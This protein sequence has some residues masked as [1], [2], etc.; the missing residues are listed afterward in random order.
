MGITYGTDWWGRRD[1]LDVIR[2]R[3]S[4]VVPSIV[5]VNHALWQDHEDYLRTLVQQA[6]D[7]R[8]V[9]GGDSARAVANRRRDAWGCLWHFPG[10]YL[11]GQVI[12]HPLDDW[13]D[14]SS[15][16]PPDPEDYTDWA[17]ARERIAEAKRQGRLAV[18]GVEHGFL[19]LRLQYLRGFEGLMLDIGEAKPQLSE[20]IEV[21]TDYW[22]EVVRRWLDA[23]V[24]IVQF[25]DDLGHQH[26]LPMRPETWRQVILP[27]Y[28]RLFAL[29]READVEVYLHT[30]GYIVDIIPDLIDAGVT[31]LNPQDL[32]NGIERL[33]DLTWGK[34]SLD[35]DID[36]QSVTVF[37]TPEEIDDHIGRCVRTLGSPQG[38]L[39]LIYGAY[40]GTPAENVGA[41]MLAMQK[42]HTY[43][44]RG[45]D[46]ASG[47]GITNGEDGV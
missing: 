22:A 5:A 46:A 9:A 35:L 17:Q 30:D 14:W 31:I 20:L 44:A 11:D 7:V 47:R 39:S 27:S 16:R 19:Y 24:D 3:G 37:G 4:G 38:G 25:A 15:Y 36:R 29:C 12:E 32:V 2:R 43:W 41:V 34:V 42:H 28:R 10:D 6:P 21:V 18:G 1:L 33:R 26:A 13:A 8:V 45:R 23:G 40:P